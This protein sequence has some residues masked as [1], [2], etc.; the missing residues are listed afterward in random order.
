VPN[1]L[2]GVAAASNQPE[3][4]VLFPSAQ[5]NGLE[6]SDLPVSAQ[7]FLRHFSPVVAG[8]T[9]DTI[10]RQGKNAIVDYETKALDFNRSY[11]VRNFIKCLAVARLS[12]FCFSDLTGEAC[13]YGS[14]LGP[15]ALAMS[16]VY[17]KLRFSLFDKSEAQ[18]ELVKTFQEIGLLPSS[19][20]GT[21]RTV[22]FTSTR[23]CSVRLFSY[24]FCE[25]RAIYENKVSLLNTIGK[26]AIIVDYP[27]VVERIY[28]E[29]ITSG[30][31]CTAISSL[32]LPLGPSLS[33]PIRQN[34]ISI[35]GGVFQVD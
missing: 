8:S 33:E 15:F 10:S 11:F 17:P 20:T 5:S 13:D 1:R 16:T 14:G 26:S 29:C 35:S 31:R 28:G 30:Y 32:K 18:I 34:E 9:Q 2:R 21:L 7:R 6:R 19:F 4:M 27:E 3:W 23:E 22:P 24:F 25:N 12:E